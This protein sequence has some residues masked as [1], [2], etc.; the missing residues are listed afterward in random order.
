MFAEIMEQT[1][2]FSSSHKEIKKK[3]SVIFFNLVKF[4]L[5][6]FEVKIH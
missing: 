1:K 5:H 4:Q 3:Y 6:I 2:H